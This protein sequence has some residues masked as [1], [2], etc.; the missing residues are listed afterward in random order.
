MCGQVQH[1]TIISGNRPYRDRSK[2]QITLALWFWN[3]TWT[4][5]TLSPVSAA[6]VSLT[7]KICNI[8]NIEILACQSRRRNTSCAVHRE[9][10]RPHPTQKLRNIQRSAKSQIQ[11]VASLQWRDSA[12][13]GK[14]GEEA[15]FI[16]VCILRS[17]PGFL[18]LWNLGLQV[19]LR[20]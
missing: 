17:I 1:S 20:Y 11:S 4:T 5:R 9:P 6:R 10:N 3:H 18:I 13:P 14:W 16:Q 2:K 8:R 19:V 12:S 7:L 15:A